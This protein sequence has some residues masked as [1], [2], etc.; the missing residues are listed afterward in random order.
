MNRTLYQ[1]L[2]THM[3]L[4]TPTRLDWKMSLSIP[5]WGNFTRSPSAAMDL[6]VTTNI[7]K[8][9]PS[10]T[11]FSANM[12]ARNH[13][14]SLADH[15]DQSWSPKPIV[16][17]SLTSATW[18]PY[19]VRPMTTS[20]M[21]LMEALPQGFVSCVRPK[22]EMVM[23]LYMGW[24]LLGRLPEVFRT[25]NPVKPFGSGTRSSSTLATFYCWR[26]GAPKEI[27]V[28]IKKKGAWRTP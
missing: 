24:I 12:V 28:Q 27:I 23:E 20:P 19:K 16:C 3:K 21:R 14:K 26:K 7:T 11:S 6:R 22:G 10:N 1:T 4:R 15:H 13:P 25:F 17:K 18:I 5:H 8:K 9:I 2:S